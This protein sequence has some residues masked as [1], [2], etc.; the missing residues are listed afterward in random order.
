MTGQGTK[1]PLMFWIISV[2]LLLWAAA[3][4]FALYMHVTLDPT[5]QPDM[6][7]YDRAYFAALPAWFVYVYGLAVIPAFVGAVALLLR[8][9]VAQPLF[10]ASII[11]VVIQ[12]GY[13][14]GATDLIAHKGAAATVPFP[15]FILLMAVAQYWLARVFIRRGWIA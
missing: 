9:R 14:F 2:V 7:D 11:G 4:M 8:S 13:V 12:F 6:T 10:L 1:P 3:G 5:K 15:L